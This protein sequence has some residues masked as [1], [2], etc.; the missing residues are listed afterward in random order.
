MI[1]Y[2]FTINDMTSYI[3]IR[4]LSSLN[5]ECANYNLKIQISTN[6][7]ADKIFTLIQNAA[8]KYNSSSLKTLS[9]PLVSKK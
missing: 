9:L 7:E 6:T 2:S 3:D 8:D 5:L 1:E 4:N